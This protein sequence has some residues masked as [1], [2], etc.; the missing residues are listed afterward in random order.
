MLKAAERLDRDF[1]VTARVWSVTSFTELARNGADTERW[2]LLNPTEPSIRSYIGKHLDGEIPVVAAT[3]YMKSHAESVGSY[4]DA[5]YR[6]L[7]T[8]GF[9]RSDTRA[10]LRRHFEIDEQ[11]VTLSALKELADRQMIADRDVENAL[12]DFNIDPNKP[13][14]RLA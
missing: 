2:N 6:V 14:P 8:D 7:G 13:E 9:G 5:P 3:D 10:A 4:F 11:F 1:D 12:R